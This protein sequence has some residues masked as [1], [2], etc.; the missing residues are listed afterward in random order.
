MDG[1]KEGE[2][3]VVGVNVGALIEEE[4]REGEE[5]EYDRLYRRFDGEALLM[6]GSSIFV[7]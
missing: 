7:R 3:G 1:W 4:G 5:K 2:Y 6:K